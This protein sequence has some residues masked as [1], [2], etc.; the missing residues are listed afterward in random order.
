LKSPQEAEEEYK[1]T[2][3]NKKYRKYY[4][5]NKIPKYCEINKIKCKNMVKYKKS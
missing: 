4:V 5:C 1:N 3:N 2:I